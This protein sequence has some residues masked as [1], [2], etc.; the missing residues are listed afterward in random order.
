ML[1]SLEEARAG[2]IRH[3][4]GQGWSEEQ[5][6]VDALRPEEVFRI[7]GCVQKDEEQSKQL[8]LKLVDVIAGFPIYQNLPVKEAKLP[9]SDEGGGEF[10]YVQ[11]K[12][13]EGAVIFG[14][15]RIFN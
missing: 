15:N 7:Y 3:Y 1:V 13:R 8:A 5:L 12:S 11:K 10:S 2:I 6:C 4:K 14:Q 9:A